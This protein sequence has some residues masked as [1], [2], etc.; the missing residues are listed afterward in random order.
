MSQITLMLLAYEMIINPS[1]QVE[2][3]YQ[4]LSQADR[5]I[6]NELIQKQDVLP[7]EIQEMLEEDHEGGDF[8]HLRSPCYESC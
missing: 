7:L 5:I 4:S 8:L 3:E 1:P 2:H 6:V